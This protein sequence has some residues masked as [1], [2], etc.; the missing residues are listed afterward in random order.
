MKKIYLLLITLCVALNSIADTWDGT[1][2]KAWAKGSGTSSDPYLI[3]SAANMAYF[4]DMIISGLTYSG[5]YFKLTTSIDFNEEKFCI[6][7]TFS[8]VFDG[9]G[10]E[11]T[12]INNLNQYESLF[13]KIKNATI[14]NLVVSIRDYVIGT[15]SGGS[16]LNVTKKQPASYNS[17]IRGIVQNAT[18]VTIDGCTNNAYISGAGI[19][20][21]GVNV[22]ISNCVNYGSIVSGVYEAYYSSMGGYKKIT[23]AAGIIGLC[24]GNSTIKNCINHGDVKNSASSAT[25]QFSSGIVGY[26]CY[27]DKKAE[28]V[29]VRN[30][31]NT[32]YILSQ[33][34]AGARPVSAGIV[35]ISHYREERDSLKIFTCYNRGEVDATTTYNDATKG[36]IVTANQTYLNIMLIMSNCYCT[37][38]LDFCGCV[39]CSVGDYNFQAKNCYFRSFNSSNNPALLY[40]TEAYMKTTD[41]LVELN[42]STNEYQMDVD[43]ENDGFPI[44]RKSYTITAKTNNSSMGTV[45][46]GGTY[47]YEA[48]ATI[49]ATPKTGYQFVKWDDG[50]TNATR[51]VTVTKD[52]TY[53][54]TFSVE[55]YTLTVTSANTT[56]GTVTGG[57]AYEYN[58]SV[59]ITATPKEHYHFV[60]WSDGNT[61]ASRTITVTKA[62]TY[63]A[64][65]AA[66]T[67]V[68]TVS[69][70][71]TNMG[72]VTGGGTYD[73]NKSVTITAT[74]KTGY[75]FVKWS[76]GNTSASRTVTVTQAATYT[77]SFAIDTYA[78]TVM[79]GN[80]TMGTVTGGGTY[81]YNKSVTI[82][83]TPKEKY[84]FEKW[85]DGNTTA[86]R[87]VTVTADA[88]YTA[89][90]AIDTY[91]LTV[92]SADTNMGTVS[93][94]GTY[95]YNKSVTITATPKTGYHFVKWNDDNTNASRSVTVTADA[96]YTATFEVNSYDITVLSADESVGNVSGSGSYNYATM[97]TIS[98]TAKEHYHFQKWNDGNT[99]N[100]RTITISE[101]ATYTALFAIDTFAISVVANNAEMGT[102]NGSGNYIY[103]SEQ[104]IE[105]TANYGYVFKNWKDGETDAQRTVTVTQN[106]TYTAIFEKEKFSVS[107]SSSDDSK[108][109][110]SAG[111]EIEY[112]S[113]IQ[114]VATPKEHYHFVKWSDGNT[115]ATR[116][117]TVTKDLS[118]SADFAIDTFELTMTNSEGGTVTGAGEYAYDETV[119]LTATPNEH[120]S[121]VQWSD[122]DKTNPRQ[123]V[124]T[125]NLSLTAEFIMDE[126]T[127]SC[128]SIANGVISGEGTYA[129]GTNVNVLATPNAHYH[130]V[131]WNDGI[132]DNPRKVTVTGN[133]S[134]SPIFEIDVLTVTFI[135]YDGTPL[136]TEAVEYG[137]DATA[138][139]VQNRTGFIFTGWDKAFTNVTE[140][141]TVT[142]LYTEKTKASYV[143]LDNAIT[144][145]QFMNEDEFTTASWTTLTTALNNAIAVDRNLYEENQSVI[146]NA[147]AVLQNAMKNVVQKTFSVTFM[148]NE[149][150][151]SRQT[152][153]YAQAATTPQEPTKLGHT[154]VGWDSDYSSVTSDMTITAIFEINTY[155]VMFLDYDGSNLKTE[156]VD[157]NQSATEPEQKPTRVGYNFTGWDK[158]FKNIRED[159]I[160]TAVYSEKAKASYIMLDRTITSAEALNESDYEDT[161]WT[162]ML[163]KLLEAKTIDRNL[164][165]EDQSIVNQ[166]NN[167]LQQA[168]NGLKLLNKSN[169]VIAINNAQNA[170][171]KAEGKIGDEI[172]QYPQSSVD[173]LT[174]IIQTANTIYSNSKKQ[175]E[176]D[177]QIRLIEIAIQEFS[178]SINKKIVTISDLMNLIEQADLL[179]SSADE[180]PGTFSLIDYMNLF[181][182]R[183]S[184]ENILDKGNPSESSLL[185]QAGKLEKV[186]AAFQDSFVLAID[187]VDTSIKVYARDNV[188]YVEQ[189]RNDAIYVYTVAG[190]L[191]YSVVSPLE[192]TM[193]PVSMKGVYFVKIG[194]KTFKTIVK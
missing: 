19:C 66:D 103:G 193:I 154:F 133:I 81:E 56:M 82:T 111:G 116:T 63:T 170:L 70:A 135:D 64:T 87:S 5:T 9:N 55:T 124:I 72:T 34:T 90:F 165:S 109:T 6:S 3:E 53:T 134:F 74:P 171:S 153:K 127:L 102:V 12:N 10:K 20:W 48:T 75:H 27:D 96:T 158:T 23:I 172:G 126:F 91:V 86:S 46:G 191:I 157:Y 68:L 62:A 163:T 178:A 190:K 186:I 145:A 150:T 159:L 139:Q 52:A 92:T 17:T 140:N 117:V 110:V 121:F 16:I 30:C 14:K 107:I 44:F 36:S 4:R 122:G 2:V 1:S 148:A 161:T 26:S 182:A 60:K 183:N 11:I 108:G 95:D 89:T 188:I 97:Q 118:L 29:T 101:T 37:N 129:Y 173:M 160:V 152:V 120:Y 138:P 22:K 194:E 28:S 78:L 151:I 7:E 65:F 113:E 146:D 164:Y 175:A 156:E 167:S 180:H 162:A 130:F 18:N 25:H 88:T 119:T 39:N 104:D 31:Y 73:Y 184:A 155:T 147:T 177:E 123:L 100:P 166:A 131:S 77:A 69:S 33:S 93:G 61:T 125:K 71:N 47:K 168:I 189:S 115:E 106:A 137:K 105:A 54:A 51:T 83:A 141:L 84:H 112:L 192:N 40:K 8:G 174:N 142:A 58:K 99:D 45:S 21:K 132:T 98:A 179:L 76:D 144:T 85:N 13:L 185:L 149:K 43:N 176:I 49:T 32:G 42:G 41:F 38:Q 59:T 143:A 50:N 79:S 136:K 24:S 57:G 94:G 80:T 169:L 187:D 15:M 67:Y 181:D 128:G 35:A 114:L